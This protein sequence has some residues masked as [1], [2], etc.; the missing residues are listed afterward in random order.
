MVG[1]NFQQGS[2]STGASSEHQLANLEV[3]L[4]PGAPD[5]VL[6]TPSLYF[7][8]EC[9]WH[10]AGKV[11]CVCASFLFLNHLKDIFEKFESVV[12]ELSSPHPLPHPVP[13]E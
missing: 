12:A 4:R 1:A 3:A 8:R 6:R 2:P 13:Q 9:M 10:L 7:P 5:C 11:G